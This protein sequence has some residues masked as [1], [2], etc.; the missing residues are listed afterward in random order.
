MK[1]FRFRLEKVLRARRLMADVARRDLGVAAQARRRCE[2]Q[3]HAL[4]EEQEDAVQSLHEL[5]ASGAIETAPV[6]VTAFTI[7]RLG[8]LIADATARVDEA[9]AQEDA[10]RVV[11]AVARRDMRVVEDL[12]E[13]ALRSH[14]EE[15]AKEELAEIE[16]MALRRKTA[17]AVP[18]GES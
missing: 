10:K 6:L 7:D 14:R 2:E 12:R 9:T 15:C 11:L 18:G 13:K 1:R 8:D 5:Q 16:E 17:A 4:A 3:L